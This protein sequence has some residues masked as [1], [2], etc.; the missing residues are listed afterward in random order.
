MILLWGVPTEGPLA[1]VGAE[2]EKLEAPYYVLDQ[3]RTTQ[4]QFRLDRNGVIEYL[5]CDGDDLELG[6]VR[7]CYLRPYD[8]RTLPAIARAGPQSKEWS[9][10]LALDESLLCWAEMT[11]ARVVNRP[12]SMLSNGS[13]PYQLSLIAAAGFTV[14]Q[15]LVTNDIEELELFWH[16]HGQV[17]YKSVSGMRSRIARLGAG[18]LA[19]RR[20][21]LAHCPT[22][23]Q[24]YIAG[25]DYRVHLVGQEVF[26]CEIHCDRDDYRFTDEGAIPQVTSTNLPPEV[27]SLCARL[28]ASMGLLVSGIDLRR[29]ADD[30]WYCFEVNPSPA[31]TYYEQYTGQPIAAAI[32]RVLASS[33]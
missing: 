5:S 10:A 18:I 17:V 21:D 28:T 15:T 29:T 25:V 6:N 22:Q 33:S 9:R 30:R 24:E 7:S 3:R 23:F 32:A 14:P 13:K 2:L 1:V 8:V 4:T 16:R 27:A 20:D 19:E 12:S 26:G 31:F 11:G